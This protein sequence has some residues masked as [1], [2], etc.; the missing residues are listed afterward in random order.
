MILRNIILHILLFLS[1][2]LY[3]QHYFWHQFSQGNYISDY[4]RQHT[5][6]IL[7]AKHVFGEVLKVDSLNNLLFI[8][9]LNEVR[10]FTVD[11]EFVRVIPFTSLHDVLDLQIDPIKQEIYLLRESYGSS[12]VTRMNYFG[13][14]QDTLISGLT[15]IPSTLILDLFHSKMY[16]GD[17]S[18]S[19]DSNYFY[20][21]DINGSNKKLTF[22][23]TKNARYIQFDAK[24]NTLYYTNVS[25]DQFV[26]RKLDSSQS[27]VL[28]DYEDTNIWVRDAVFDVPNETIYF[29]DG[30]TDAVFRYNWSTHTLDREFDVH[31]DVE[32]MD[33]VNNSLYFIEFDYSNSL[34]KKYDTSLK[35]LDLVKE[36]ED[37]FYLSRIDEEDQ[38]FVG[39]S[40][41]R[42]ISTYD[43]NGDFL[44]HHTIRGMDEISDMVLVNNR[45]YLNDGRAL[46]STNQNFMDLQFHRKLKGAGVDYFTYNSNDNMLYFA[47]SSDGEIW[48]CDLDGANYELVYKLKS[49]QSSSDYQFNEIVYSEYN[50]K[51]YLTS[52]G[53]RK[54]ISIN[55][56]GSGFS[57]TYSGSYFESYYSLAIDDT[58]Q[59]L[60]YVY[61]KD[62]VIYKTDIETGTRSIYAF[63]A[64][65]IDRILY[66][67]EEDNLYAFNDEENVIYQI[68]DQNINTLNTFDDYVY[69]RAFAYNNGQFYIG[70]NDSHEGILKIDPA[71]GESQK[72]L[73][74]NSSFNYNEYL[75]K[76]KDELYGTIR[77]SSYSSKDLLYKINL[78]T[79]SITHFFE[80]KPWDGFAIYPE[81]NTCFYISESENFDDFV[82]KLDL[83]TGK[84]DSFSIVPSG[85]NLHVHLLQHPVDHR[86]YITTTSSEYKISSID[87]SGGDLR[88]EP[89][90][91]FSGVIDPKVINP[92]DNTI[93]FPESNFNQD[94]FY[95]W[96]IESGEI[97][98]HGKEENRISRWS[99]NVIDSYYN[100]DEDQDGFAFVMDCNDN[101]PSINPDAIEIPDNNIDENCD[102]I[103]GITD[104]DGDGIGILYD[105]NDQDSLVNLYS[106]EIP[107]NDIDENCDGIILIIDEDSDGFNSDEDCDDS[108]PEIN[109]EA[110]EISDNYID[111]NCDG[112]LDGIDEDGDGFFA[113]LDCDD[114]NADVNPDAEEIVY[115]GIDDDC[116]EE[117][118]DDD[119]D[120]DGYLNYLDCDD[121]NA[122]VNPNVVEIPYNGIDDDCD[123]STLDDDLD[124]DGYPIAEDCDDND[125]SINP[126]SEEIPDNDIDEN[127]DGIILTSVNNK[128]K[129]SLKIFPNPTTGKFKISIDN[130]KI[131]LIQV[132]DAN[133]QLISTLKDMT[134]VDMSAFSSGVYILKI[135]VE[136]KWYYRKLLKI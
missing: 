133:G 81:N 4:E 93:T 125:S 6:N 120:Q 136:D 116:N 89:Y 28:Y 92:V 113:G 95:R 32:C 105:C 109:P 56:D 17:S 66:N 91:G 38:Y 94:I 20:E 90:S 75:D 1:F 51:L 19:D 15:D 69:T 40:G 25:T 5:K 61:P 80:I 82:V 8:S 85:T 44:K 127:C 134:T 21:Y 37:V 27:N 33:V 10:I 100:I 35:S 131:S 34:L 115:N 86:M 112:I 99:M 104:E 29:Q 65:P 9:G 119:L 52:R 103:L 102:G 106:P 110:E 121:N 71:T 108:D 76:E 128:E 7:P 49:F 83:V 132:A 55:P 2:N 50:N 36:S 88:A 18:E 63:N 122:E 23:L 107:N 129:S 87:S 53:T 11:G 72:I 67:K 60:Y 123:E 39:V 78:N 42:R 41:S 3:S 111:E 12:L 46:F 73:H 118:L 54:I 43:L 24:S 62:N 47:S 124:E 68:S 57:S 58:G 79:D 48:K 126:S 22:L 45:Y 98:Q 74:K 117:T 59:F 13:K 16:I 31:G 96:N 114:G 97:T 64:P 77:S 101:D 135:K 130:G 70:L 26:Q 30:K 14:Q 84:R